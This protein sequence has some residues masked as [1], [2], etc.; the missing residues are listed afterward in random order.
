MK[1]KLARNCEAALR[2]WCKK[3]KMEITSIRHLHPRAYVVGKCGSSCLV[4]ALPWADAEPALKQHEKDNGL[5][6]VT[7][8][9]HRLKTGDWCTYAYISTER[10]GEPV[11]IEVVA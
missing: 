11:A 6:T 4:V 1:T 10:G 7:V 3:E 2:A 8:F 5:D 9:D